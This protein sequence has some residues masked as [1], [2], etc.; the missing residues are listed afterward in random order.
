MASFICGIDIGGTFTDCVVI[1]EAG[2]VTIEKSPS[3]PHDFSVGF[4]NALRQAA[5]GRGMTLEELL[6]G[7]VTL[8]HGTT[9]ATN[10]AVELKGASVGLIATAGHGDAIIIMRSLG[11]VAG[12]PAGDLLKYSAAAKPKP[13]I[14]R[15]L[16]E[17]VHERVDYKGE[18]VVELDEEGAERAI[19]GLVEKGVEGIAIALLWSFRNPS[20]EQ[21]IKEIAEQIAPDLFV[22]C[23]SDV[24]PKL[25][26]YE[27][28]VAT[29]L[30][31]YV[32]PVSSRYVDR[33]D[34]TARAGGLDAP[35]LLM[36]CNG[37]LA[38]PSETKKSP[39]LLLQSGPVAGVV[40][41]RYLGEVMGY[42]NIICTDVGG[43]T[44]D[45]GLVHDGVPSTSHTSLVGQY[46]YSVPM[47]DVKSI[48]AG[49]GSIAW[50]DE[51]RNVL[52]VGPQSA[53]AVPGPVCYGGGGT[54]PTVTDADV[55]LGYL[56]AEF[57][58]GGRK[59]LDRGAAEDA[60]RKIG[61]PLGLDVMQTAAGI[62]RIAEIGMADLIRK[63]T[64]E[65]G[66]D[67]RDF[68]VFAFGGAGP[69][70]AAGYSK[71]LGVREVVVPLGAVGSVWCALGVA[72]S[73]ILHVYEREEIMAAP[74]DGPR[75]DAIRADLRERALRQL[76]GEGV[77]DEHISLTWSV[78]LRHRLQVHELEVP[79]TDSDV[80]L[81]EAALEQL[82]DD[83]EAAYEALYGAG[84]AYRAA[85]VELVTLRCRAVGT[86]QKPK[87]VRQEEGSPTPGSDARAPRR[88]V[89]WPELERAEQTDIYRG[90]A[91]VPGNVVPGPA[92]IETSVTTVVVHPQQSAKV[93]GYG[94]IVISL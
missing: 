43:T 87:L 1:D 33:I 84:T 45:V 47:I 67:P 8:A 42:R 71:E 83:F 9:V 75:I 55:V 89:Y 3:T 18:V 74:F 29:V 17:E 30:N 38:P 78:D 5:E 4:F 7:T 86:T 85:G 63:T 81:D 79:L 28:T 10:T 37:G 25:G 92:I 16:I 27:R 53:G 36:Q 23:S 11:R 88:E 90:D 21:R 93:D 49:G 46:E 40:G 24:A 26:E 20:H 2:L 14:P 91:L 48:G 44:F 13:I 66:L 19:R 82:I 65:K 59:R 39:V 12:L 34:T 15:S 22:T 62:T 32:G 57:F 77:R 68:V 50:Y 80:P 31:S 64:I 94:N 69:T 76:R 61:E 73:D 58:H 52:R 51:T 60:I 56:D 41:S 6:A 72:S 70:H 35:F 54:S